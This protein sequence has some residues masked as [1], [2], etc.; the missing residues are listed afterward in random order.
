MNI[1]P[2]LARVCPIPIVIVGRIHNVDTGTEMVTLA[3][4]QDGRWKTIAVDRMMISSP[5]DIVKLTKYG[6]PIDT[7]SARV[8]MK[9]FHDLQVVNKD[10]FPVITSVKTCGWKGS[11]SNFVLGRHKIPGG[12]IEFDLDSKGYM[13]LIDGFNTKGSYNNCKETIRSILPYPKVLFGIYASLAAPILS[14]LKQQGFTVHYAGRTSSGKTT[15]AELAASIWG[16]PENI[17]QSWNATPVFVEQLAGLMGNLPIFLDDSH[18]ACLDSKFEIIQMIANGVG[19]GRGAKQGGVRHTLRWNTVLISTGE[20]MLVDTNSYDGN[21]ARVITLWGSPFGDLN[22]GE[23]IENIKASVKDNYGYIGRAFVGGLVHALQNDKNFLNTLRHAYKDAVKKFEK[24][25]MSTRNP[26]IRRQLGYFAAVQISGQLLHIMLGLDTKIP[27][28]VVLECLRESIW[29]IDEQS[30]QSRRAY[31]LVTSWIYANANKFARD[32]CELAFE[33]F[34]EGVRNENKEYY[35]L[36]EGDFVNIFPHKLE[37]FLREKGF[38]KP[39]ILK[40]WKEDKLI[41]HDKGRPEYTVRIGK[42]TPR[43]IRI[44]LERDSQT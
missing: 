39:A 9:Y 33:S 36:W 4:F 20:G 41:E 26:I 11:H 40:L 5:S 35:G 1:Q 24:H 17:I 10:V 37:E 27:E 7:A 29:N 18:L 21:T 8:L 32:R 25:A 31:D 16:D 2:E 3:Y 38:S 34:V 43:F 30:S 22:D 44:R 12:T 42:R 15:T 6:I 23:F 19:R 28:A 14:L 13:N